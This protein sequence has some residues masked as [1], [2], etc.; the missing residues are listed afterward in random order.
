MCS[1][2]QWVEDICMLC[3]LTQHI[4]TEEKW[5]PFRR[6]RFQMHFLNENV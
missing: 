2:I 4:E 1:Y 3:E 5:P 6:R